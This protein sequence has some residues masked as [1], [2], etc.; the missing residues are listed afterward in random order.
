MESQNSVGKR[1]IW[2]VSM[3]V[4]CT[5]LTF[6]L[7][8]FISSAFPE[9]NVIYKGGIP[10]LVFVVLGLVSCGIEN[11]IIPFVN[12]VSIPKGL[13][14]IITIII[15]VAGILLQQMYFDQYSQS[16]AMSELFL[17][18]VTDGRIFENNDLSFQ[19]IYQSGLNVFSILFGYTVFA[20]SIYN[21]AYI[22]LSAVL[23]FWAVKN[24]VGKRWVANLFLVLFFISKQTLDM[25]IKPEVGVVYLL[26]VSVFLLS[27]SLVYY[28][29]TKTQNFIVQIISIFIMGCLFATLFACETNSIIFAVPAIAVSFSGQNKQEK[30]WYY[31]L[32]VEG[33]LLILIT[34]GLV[35]I[36]KPEIV[37][38]LAFEW[39]TIHAVDFE[40][41]MIL[42]LNMLGFIGVYGMWKRKMHYVIPAFM[43]IYFIFVKPD[44]SSGINGEIV[45]FVCAALY[46][47][48]G[49]GM[50]DD[51]DE[52][53][54]ERDDIVEEIPKAEPT[55]ST[56]PTPVSSPTLIVSQTPVIQQQTV[57][58]KQEQEEIQSIR[59]LNAKLNQKQ[60][61]FVP[62]S[63]KKP[64][65][66][67]KKVADYAFEPT[68][69]QMK[70]DIEVADN[71]DFD[72]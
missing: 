47:V 40:T 54:D 61:D 45:G 24:V 9:M 65:E 12:D 66:R 56:P 50:Y 25:M 13:K 14:N 20:V 16:V 29:R 55:P 72:I 44:F 53:K 15:F 59:E 62:L 51:G 31:I 28:Y 36:L 35:F 68:Y 26:M 11:F 60:P 7:S 10:A 71:D 18:F 42:L 17:D 21:R 1:I 58:E 30:M 3:V 4:L 48:L 27:V 46:A 19:G 69:E 49:I 23:L 43:S 64:K 52:T 32:A 39:P 5:F 2:A 67:E 38:N 63:F 37:M 34:C 70:Y 33:M 41:T 6:L 8:M 22:L 57:E